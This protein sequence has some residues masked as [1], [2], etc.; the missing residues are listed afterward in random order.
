MKLSR[1]HTVIKGSSPFCVIQFFTKNKRNESFCANYTELLYQ[2]SHSGI[3][4]FEGVDFLYI[5]N[6]FHLFLHFRDK[7]NRIDHANLISLI[8]Q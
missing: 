1:R 7:F 3:R 5:L 6:R 2:T 4:K 8:F